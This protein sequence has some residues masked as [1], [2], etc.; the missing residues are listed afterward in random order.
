MME[1][2]NQM[3]SVAQNEYCCEMCTR[4][5][6][7]GEKHIYASGK[8]DGEFFQRRMHLG[9]HSLCEVY[10]S[11]VDNEIFDYLDVV[12]Y[13]RD[14]YCYR[15]PKRDDCYDDA[16]MHICDCEKIQAEIKRGGK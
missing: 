1:F 11:E 8:Y 4:R 12:E 10:W 16:S 6:N 15:C 7:K 14:V 5:I 3:M 2:Y 9:C 13:F